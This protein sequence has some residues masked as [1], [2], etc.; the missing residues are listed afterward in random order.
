MAVLAVYPVVQVLDSVGAPLAGG[1]VYTYISGTS[2]P[3][4]TYTTST[5]LVTN[6]NP[7]IL[8]SRGEASIW[9]DTDAAYRFR[10]D[11]SNDVTIRTVDGVIGMQS[12]TSGGV[13]LGGDLNI[14]NYSIVDASTNEYIKFVATSSAINEM[15]VTNATTGNAPSIAATGGDTN[16]GLIL[17]GKG[18]GAVRLGQSTTTGVQL[19]ADQPIIDS[20]GN[21]YIKFS[22]TAS[23][24]NEVT[25]INAATGSGPTIAA[26]GGDTNAPITIAGKGTGAVKLGQATTTDIRL[27][28]DQPIADSAGNE[29]LKFGASGSAVN[30]IKISNAASTSYPTIEATGDDTNIGF[31]ILVKGGGVINLKGTATVPANLRFF[32][33]TGNGTNYIG[34]AAPSSVAS[35]IS[36]TLPSADATVSGQVL[37]SNASG[38][39]SF[40]TLLATPATQAEQETATST[41]AAVTPGRQQYHPSAAKVWAQYDTGTTIVA[42]YN[43]TSIT[44]NGTGNQTVNFTT[45]FSSTSYCVV[46]SAKS[47]GATA[48]TSYCSHPGTTLNTT[49]VNMLTN[50]A[51]DG[52]FADPTT[53]MM[54]AYGDQ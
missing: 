19:E 35:D 43:V 30:E 15:T 16:V 39:L 29:L 46:G 13:T 20:S 45:A 18:T 38:T 21:E 8:D 47:D 5:G 49:N 1:K 3:K 51:S 6:A 44:D 31:N 40:G 52:A 25:I 42:S 22:K 33:N 50:R 37:S 9:L 14:G 32:E 48:A 23:A 17:K 4:N 7:V 10:I 54:V 24:V 28:A 36:F 53:T 11:D 27:V 34:L 2:T 26:T 41:T 12:V